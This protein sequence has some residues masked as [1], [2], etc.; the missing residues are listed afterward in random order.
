ML[1]CSYTM[2][3]IPN[4]SY[5]LFYIPIQATQAL[6]VAR[7]WTFVAA[8]LSALC[9]SRFLP[10]GRF[11]VLIFVRGWVDPWAIVR[12]EGLGKLKKIHLIQDLNWRPSTF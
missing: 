1:I 6:M 2:Q 5:I 4:P 9:V 7:S 3:L 8:R 10:P 11:L 12:L